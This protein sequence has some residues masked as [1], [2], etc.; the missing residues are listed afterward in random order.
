MNLISVLYCHYFYYL[1][2]QF[3]F[4][5]LVQKIYRSTLTHREQ[6]AAANRLDLVKSY[7]RFAEW[8]HGDLIVRHHGYAAM[9]G[10]GGGMKDLSVSV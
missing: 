6:E 9:F 8:E 3:E 10:R 5:K 7:F 4:S 2:L 1:T